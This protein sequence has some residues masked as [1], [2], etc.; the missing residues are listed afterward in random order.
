MASLRTRRGIRHWITLAVV[1]ALRKRVVGLHKDRRKVVK[2]NTIQAIKVHVL[3]AQSKSQPISSNCRRSLAED[4]PK[5]VLRCCPYP[6][7]LIENKTQSSS[8]RDKRERSDLACYGL[9]HG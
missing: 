6:Q 1:I 7:R 3:I 4:R 8:G 2:V 5:A 9:I